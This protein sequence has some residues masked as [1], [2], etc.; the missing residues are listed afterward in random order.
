MGSRDG[1]NSEPGKFKDLRIGSY[2]DGTRFVNPGKTIPKRYKYKTT[3]KSSVESAIDES[4]LIPGLNH[5]ETK[6]FKAV[7]S[8]S[9]NK[10]SISPYSNSI[11]G[12]LDQVAMTAILNKLERLG[13]IYSPE[14]GKIAITEAGL[15]LAKENNLL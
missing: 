2:H 10:K 15:K 6:I 11:K 12:N 7:T 5:D 1:F 9:T 3:E 14:I 8:L 13:Y 4:I